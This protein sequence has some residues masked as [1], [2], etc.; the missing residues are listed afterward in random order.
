L[1]R[2][3]NFKLGRFV[4]RLRGLHARQTLVSTFVLISKSV[5]QKG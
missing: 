5:L 3:F 1:G 4:A 2:V